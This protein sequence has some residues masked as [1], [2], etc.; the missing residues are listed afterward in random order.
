ME[1]SHIRLVYFILYK[2]WF[3]ATKGITNAAKNFFGCALPIFRLAKPLTVPSP[4]F[5]LG[6]APSTEVLSAPTAGGPEGGAPLPTVTK[7]QFLKR[8]NVLEKEPIYQK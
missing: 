2:F 6:D 5:F 8:F 7:F 4:G 1:I 3:L